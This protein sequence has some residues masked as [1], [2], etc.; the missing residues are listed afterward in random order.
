[1]SPMPPNVRCSEPGWSVAVATVAP[2]WAGSLSLGH[3]ALAMRDTFLRALGSRWLG[4]V[5]T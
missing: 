3:S 1:M 5:L 2:S 4:F